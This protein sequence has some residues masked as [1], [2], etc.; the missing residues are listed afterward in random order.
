MCYCMLMATMKLFCVIIWMPIS[1]LKTVD[2]MILLYLQLLL[3]LI[4]SQWLIRS[5]WIRRQLI[6]P[7]SVLVWISPITPISQWTLSVK[8]C[9]S[10]AIR[11]IT[12]T[13]SAAILAV[14]SGRIILLSAV[15]WR[16]QPVRRSILII[17]PG[18][19]AIPV[20]AWVR[21]ARLIRV[22]F[23]PLAVRAT[24]FCTSMKPM[25]RRTLR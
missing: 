22:C 3:Q 25:A 8:W 5:Q 7:S 20:L 6:T 11:T 16:W 15:L 21:R 1:S 4:Q 18:G 9:S 17:S 10:L 24:C 2:Y 14:T 12:A 19:M 13:I 23:Q